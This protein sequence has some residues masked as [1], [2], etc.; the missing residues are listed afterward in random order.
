M[1]RS[2][3]LTFACA[4]TILVATPPAAAQFPSQ[5]GSNRL[6]QRWVGAKMNG[7]PVWLDF[8]GD[9]M[10]VVSDNVQSR[11]ADYSLAPGRVTIYGDSV[12]MRIL[13]T[14]FNGNREGEDFG[15][16]RQFELSYRFSLDRM[17]VSAG[18]RSITMTAQNRLGRPLEANWIADLPDGR[19]MELR[20]QGSGSALYRF[21]PGGSWRVGEWDRNFRDISFDW[22]PPDIEEPDSSL[23]WA[24]IYDADGQQILL[25]DI[26]DGSSVT[27]FRRIIR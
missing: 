15:F 24:G 27:I 11:D 21:V 6:L 26:V 4:V 9:S 19:R 5:D 7:L 14:S 25:E 1:I 8:F 18:G 16:L 10:I 20:L 17:I 13:A 12:V 2:V 23:I 3:S 22:N